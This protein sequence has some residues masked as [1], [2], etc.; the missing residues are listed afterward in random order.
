MAKA[1]PPTEAARQDP[2]D[3]FKMRTIEQILTLF[4]GGDFLKEVME[5]HQ[6]LMIGLLDHSEQH[7]S[8]GC[9][10]SMTLKISYALGK[11]G[12]VAMGAK[13]TFE[14]PKKPPASTAA[15]VNDKGELMLYSPFMARMHQPV[16]D[17]T[18]HDPETGEIRD[19]G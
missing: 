4:D 18:D 10:G 13:S 19:P 6:Q 9:Q 7:G 3:K 14:A 1:K 12:D 8:K 17:V 5:G 15:F 11:S 2:Y 16:K